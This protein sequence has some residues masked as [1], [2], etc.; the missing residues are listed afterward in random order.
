[1]S[2]RRQSKTPTR[3]GPAEWFTGDVEYPETST[4]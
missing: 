1:M 2:T 4:S 3:K